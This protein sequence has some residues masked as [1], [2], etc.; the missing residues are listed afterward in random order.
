MYWGEPRIRI[1][2]PDDTAACLTYKK[3][4]CNEVQAFKENGIKLAFSIKE[5][6]DSL[7]K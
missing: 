7:I 3:N 5:Q 2:L 6:I 1:S 4:V